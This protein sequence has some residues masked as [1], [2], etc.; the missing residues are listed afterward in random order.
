MLT[1]LVKFLAD[2]WKH[3]EQAP[4]VGSHRTQRTEHQS[5]TLQIICLTTILL[6][7]I[8]PVVNA[9][10]SNWPFTGVDIWI[11]PIRYV[12]MR[13]SHANCIFLSFDCD[14]VLYSFIN[15]SMFHILVFADVSVCFCLCIHF[16]S[17]ILKLD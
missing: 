6:T 9:L 13:Y 15:L 17:R 7:Y 1:K 14:L 8:F 16:L 2:T 5:N 11:F 12:R 10:S 4:L 3:R